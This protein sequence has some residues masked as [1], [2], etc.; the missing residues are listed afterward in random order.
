MVKRLPAARSEG[1]C[2][3]TCVQV[4][5][6]VSEEGVLSFARIRFPSWIENCS[7][8]ISAPS[9]ADVR[10]RAFLSLPVKA[11]KREI[12]NCRLVTV[13]RQDVRVSKKICIPHEYCSKT[14]VGICN[15]LC[16]SIALSKLS[17]RALFSSMYC[18]MSGSRAAENCSRSCAA[19]FDCPGKSA[20]LL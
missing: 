8:A 16:K 17:S 2:R 10:F 9:A 14:S 3:R 6:V 1:V 5:S 7:S 19:W 4:A 18:L 11:G 15:S 12:F 13:S 20:Y